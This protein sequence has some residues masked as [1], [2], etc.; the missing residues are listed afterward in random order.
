[1]INIAT[2]VDRSYYDSRRGNWIDSVLHHKDAEDVA[3]MM[4]MGDPG[5]IKHDGL[6]VLTVDPG[7]VKHSRHTNLTNRKNFICLES[8][9]FVDFYDFNDDDILILCDWALHRDIPIA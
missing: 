5:N 9:E 1:M 3:M 8:G 6:E 7:A 4:F 2:N